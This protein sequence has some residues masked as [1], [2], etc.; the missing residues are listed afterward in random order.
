MKGLAAAAALVAAL[1]LVP[2]AFATDV[3]ADEL[4]SLANRAVEDREARAELVSVD[5]I[6]GQSVDLESALAGADEEELETR[7]AVL[8]EDE[9]PGA[10]DTARARASAREILSERRFDPGAEVPRP[11]R[12]LL[13]WVGGLLEPIGDLL[14]GFPGGPE[15][16]W[17]IVGAAVALAAALLAL[18]IGR[19]R[20]GRVVESRELLPRSR[21]DPARLERE[22]DEA[23][24][25]GE[26][27]RALRLRFQAGLV[28]L[29]R[30]RAIELRA[31]ST[32]GDV[33]RGLRS[34]D[35]DDV[36]QRFEEIVYGRRPAAR[37]DVEAS[38][39]GWTR[40]LEEAGVR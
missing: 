37:A 5:S 29:D 24:Q 13:E 14:R 39:A 19:G 26:L 10:L 21:V 16:G 38:R 2:A 31:S 33:R 6:D 25:R 20:A 22:A 11:F 12:R 1:A 28:R 8:T 36:A 35:F 32:T 4:V 40:V 30:A 18:R 15:L 23:E 27:E 17:S 3:T 34:P 7:L 9:R